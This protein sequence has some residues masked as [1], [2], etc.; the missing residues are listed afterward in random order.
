[1]KEILITD[2]LSR[3]N[4]NPKKTVKGV[5]RDKARSLYFAT[6]EAQNGWWFPLAAYPVVPWVPSH[7]AQQP[8]LYT[9]APVAVAQLFQ[10][11]CPT[12]GAVEANEAKLKAHARRE[13]NTQFCDLCFAHMKLFPHEHRYD[14]CPHCL[15]ILFSMVAAR[16]NDMFY[17]WFFVPKPLH[18]QG[19][20]GA[21]EESQG[22][23]P[24]APAV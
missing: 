9:R 13:H 17:H 24:A 8:C 23:V 11:R 1:M 10:Y 7:P 12:C 20:G 2:D 15:S 18:A 14:S 6:A 16:S 22:W 4:F 21:Q 19:N 5:L 3:D